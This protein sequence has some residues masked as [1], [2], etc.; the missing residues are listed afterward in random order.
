M[1]LMASA[2]ELARTLSTGSAAEQLDAAEQLAH[3]GE[4]AQP[5]AVA[6]VNALQT[7]DDA[8]RDWVVA[9]LEGLGSPATSDVASLARL[10]NAA[11]IDVAYWAAT[12]LGRLGPDAG[13]AVADLTQALQSHA[14]TVVRE[15]A[16][17]ALGKIGPT[18][19]SAKQALESATKSGDVRLAKLASEAL[20]QIGK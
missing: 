19:N 9:A 3:F 7:D 2:D 10:A 13:P 8:L 11:G 16:A 15:R 5:A 12:L 1:L 6:I 14:D 17:W 4:E 18:A 20:G